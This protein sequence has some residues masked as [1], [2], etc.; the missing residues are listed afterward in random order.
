MRPRKGST[1]IDREKTCPFLLRAFFTLD[2]FHQADAFTL[3]QLPVED[4]IHLYTWKDATLRE[5]MYL[6][7]EIRPDIQEK[8]DA[9]LNFRIVYLDQIRDRYATRDLGSVHC[10]KRGPD[11]QRTLAQMNF[12]PGEYLDI[13]LSHG[14]PLTQVRTMNAYRQ[15]FG[16]RRRRRGG[17]RY[18]GSRGQDENRRSPSRHTTSRADQVS[19][20]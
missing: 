11:D 16:D 14:P 8:S 4:E 15:A 6:V 5:L 12:L 7:Q 20:W 17:Q 2:E 18:L 3:E 1:K 9:R 13:C 19:R 10:T